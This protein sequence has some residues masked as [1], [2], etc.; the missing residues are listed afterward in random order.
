MS[1]I[2]FIGCVHVPDVLAYAVSC[3]CCVQC[4]CVHCSTCK[5]P[6]APAAA[7]AA[8]AACVAALLALCLAPAGDEFAVP[9]CC[10]APTR[11]CSG[12]VQASWR[13][14]KLHCHVLASLRGSL[15]HLSYD[16]V[17][18]SCSITAHDYF[19]RLSYDV[20]WSSCSSA[21]LTAMRLWHISCALVRNWFCA[22]RC[23][24]R[25]LH[26]SVQCVV[27][28]RLAGNRHA[29][30]AGQQ[31]LHNKSTREGSRSHL[32]VR[33]GLGDGAC[34]VAV[35]GCRRLKSVAAV[36]CK[37]VREG[38]L[39]G[40][41]RDVGWARALKSAANTMNN[42]ICATSHSTSPTLSVMA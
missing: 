15:C 29:G 23:A 35:F 40:G 1:C 28:E 16:E 38:V 14:S 33:A 13:P 22:W 8:A 18:S 17:L 37:S 11:G 31:R 6:L 19:S 5:R 42:C 4:C 36:L 41:L 21:S 9:A 30:L 10:F 26:T 3:A 2:I 25:V 12:S 32:G 39:Q 24:V 27:R 20:W 7:A 34:A